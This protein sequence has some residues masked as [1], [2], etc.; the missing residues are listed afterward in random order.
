MKDRC[1]TCGR[2][3]VDPNDHNCRQNVLTDDMKYV[4]RCARCMSGCR[5][6][7]KDGVMLTY[8]YETGKYTHLR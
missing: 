4:Q 8:D 3:R 1:R 6:G 7:D 5:C 2:L